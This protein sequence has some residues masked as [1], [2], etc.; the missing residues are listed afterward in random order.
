M[1]KALRFL[2]SSSLLLLFVPLLSGCN[3][4][5]AP[6]TGSDPAQTEGNTAPPGRL[7]GASFQTL[8]N[9]FFV[10][11]G[12][13]LQKE[14][15][16]HGDELII[17]DAQFNSLKQKNDLSDLI[18]KDVAGIFV[19]PVNWE[20]LK[21][22]LLEA[23]RKNVPIIIV[24]A[25][26]KESDEELIV[27]TVASDNVRAGQL[28][29]EALAKVN[30][31]AKLVVLH[32]SVN[33]ACIDR[34]AGFKETLQ[35]YPEMEI[36]DVQEAKGTTEGARPVMRDL[37]GRYPDLNAVFAIN[38]PN[39]LGVISALDSANK[40]DDVT[41]VTVDGS[42][43]GIKAIQAGKLHSTSAQ[44]P[45][46]I[47]KIAAEKMLAHLNGEPVEKDVKVRVELITAENA[48]QHLEAD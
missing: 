25:P 6:G 41:I 1:N 35:K 12:N 44:F 15:A 45:K 29:A 39:A 11:L 31:K 42:Q 18:L 43:A 21:G 5:S 19:N 28:A 48:E 8:N 32:L 16:A 46:E 27:C 10:D 34:V 13:G 38:D 24:D 14:L 26:V 20:G 30:P 47:G 3:D 9:P 4:S 17:L 40:L 22:S 2:I 37:I 33:K 23:Q 36:L 7:F